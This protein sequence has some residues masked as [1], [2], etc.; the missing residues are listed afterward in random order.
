MSA[1]L[2]TIEGNP[3]VDI[4]FEIRGVPASIERAVSDA[5]RERRHPPLT[6]KQWLALMDL[7]PDSPLMPLAYEA[8]NSWDHLPTLTLK[9]H[10]RKVF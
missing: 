7:S 4:T 8:V 10:A 6:I 9:A 1:R 3:S 2:E 5:V